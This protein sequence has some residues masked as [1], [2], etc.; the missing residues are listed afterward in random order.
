[1]M[2]IKVSNA[3]PAAAFNADALVI[4]LPAAYGA[5]QPMP[6]VPAIA[7]NAAFNTN[8]TD[9]YAHVATGSAA[10][11]TLDFSTSVNGAVTLTGLTL[12]TSGGTAGAG[13]VVVKNDIPGSGT[14]YD[15][16]HPPTVV[17]NNVVNGVNCLSANGIS[18]S[19]TAV[20][21]Q[22]TPAKPN[23]PAIPSTRQVTKITDF[24]AG[25]GYTCAPTI[26]FSNPPG[27]NGIGA[28]VTVSS[29]HMSQIAVL[30]KAEQELFDASG[31]YNTT[32]GIELPLTNGV[33]QTTVPLNYFDSA[34]EFIKDGEVQIWK[35]VDNGFW[36]NSMHF[37]MVDVQLI[38]R[39]GWDGTVKAPATNEV[40]WRDT[41]RLNPLEDVIIAMRAKRPTI[42]FGLPQSN[43][44]LD[45][46]KPLNTT[47]ASASG[48]GFTTAAGVPNLQS[49]NVKDNFDNEFTWGSAILGHAENDF[50]RPVVFQPTVTKP[51][52]PSNLN[53][54]AGTGMLT[55]TDPTPVAAATTM[56][57]AQN[58][59]GF[60]ILQANV[61][62]VGN[63]GAFTPVLSAAG[64]PVT[65]PANVTSW[66]LPLP[67]DPALGYAV[68]AY[69]AAGDSAPSAGFMEQMPIAPTTF[70]AEPVV[71]NSVTLT[72]SGASTSNKLEVWRNG[73]L[74]ATLPGTATGYVDNAANA[75]LNKYTPAVSALA[76]YVYQI[77]AVNA[78]APVPTGVAVSALLEVITPMEF[79]AAPTIQ[80]ATTNVAGTQVTLTWTDNANNETA[81]LVEWATDGVTFNN[82]LPLIP[83]NPNQKKATLKA[84]SS[85]IP[86]TPGS[87]YTFRVTAVN[88]TGAATS[89]SAPVLSLPV[90][91]TAGVAPTAPAT[92]TATT[93]KLTWPA[94][95]GI[96]ANATVSY[97]VQQSVNGGPY[98]AIAGSPFT[99]RNAN[100]TS[101]TGNDYTYQ[102]Q[103]LATRYGL[104]AVTSGV[105]TSNK[106]SMAP[107]ASTTPVATAGVAGS[108]KITVTWTNTS[109][110][111]TGFTVQRRL[112][113]NGGWTTI[114]PA[115]TPAA[116]SYSF[117]DTAPAAG[118]YSY[119]V[120]ATSLGGNTTAT[121]NAVV[122]P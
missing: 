81:Y 45:P 41:L 102:V 95:T 38:N 34:T 64:V 75:A 79:V 39:V 110:N 8:D 6:I 74:I 15:P 28:Q 76:K 10:Q 11:P 119:R 108:K 55:W 113:N 63:L 18:A 2:Q 42:P 50:T 115:I 54:P 25:S 19:A 69:N 51:N 70:K 99:A 109:N 3:A 88:V 116:T 22:G 17:F 83:R 85:T 121:S 72:W 107:A 24:V 117:T 53:D 100:V 78:L 30:T 9:I 105:T 91:L 4:A 68:V 104:A 31:R 62:N 12:V 86:T 65:V 112:G 111:I 87:V 98:V 80:S 90:D 71:F 96:S 40:G 84:V 106:V 103:A 21:D 120:T 57:N 27:T 92:L 49:S 97:V 14:G 94:A 82:Q 66:T 23:T 122:A 35:L 114:L 36:S 32:G 7:Y 16:I 93:T 5:S 1:M 29:T 56:A 44:L 37:D 118:S 59:I 67:I 101:A 43:R 20:V 61:D 47:G 73:V 89:T 46:S 58:E 60:K 13:G 77:K 33:I 48:L 26:T 52:A